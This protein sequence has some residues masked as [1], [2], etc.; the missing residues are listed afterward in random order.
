MISRSLRCT[1]IRIHTQ[2][3]TSLALS[4]VLWILWYKLV[5][6][7]SDV[8]SENPTWCVVLHIFTQYAMVCNYF[9]MFCEGV[10]LHLVL[11]VVFIKDN[12]AMRIFI[13]IGWIL[14]MIYVAIYA[15]MRSRNHEDS[16]LW[17]VN[18][19]DVIWFTISRLSV[20]GLR[21][22]ITCGSLLFQ[23][24]FYSSARQYSL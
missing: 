5:V 15:I 6:D 20:A 8:I 4:C 3:F 2:L 10:H 14:P 9:W 17:E 23:F 18:L 19:S 1:R 21:K 12:V 11:V 22:V 24:W 7:S 16:K 13:F